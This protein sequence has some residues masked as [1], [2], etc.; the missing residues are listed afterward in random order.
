M[1]RSSVSPLSAYGPQWECPFFDL[2]SYSRGSMKER[3]HH[4][5]CTPSAAPLHMQR[6]PFKHLPS[7][8]LSSIRY[9]LA[10]SGTGFGCQLHHVSASSNNRAA[11]WFRISQVMLRGGGRGRDNDSRGGR[12]LQRLTA[13]RNALVVG[14]ADPSIWFCSRLTPHS[15]GVHDRCI[16]DW[17][18]VVELVRA[19]V[20]GRPPRSGDRV[21]S[22]A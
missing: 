22:L 6:G 1:R 17:T 4:H 8:G 10:V 13:H 21:A 11:P 9:E 7:C 15:S 18:T 2:Q 3:R 20:V 16:V 12:G 14:H 19:S 5:V